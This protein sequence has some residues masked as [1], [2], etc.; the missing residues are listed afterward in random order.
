MRWPWRGRDAGKGREPEHLRTGRWGEREAERY[1]QALGFR[2]LG[3]RLRVG[4]RDE[5][6]LLARDKD[7]LVFVEVKTR[8]SE[9][10]GRPA[11]AVDRN[12]RQALSRA[13]LRYM[14]KLKRKPDFFRFDVVEVV[15]HPDE[16]KPEVTHIRSA[17]TMS[18]RYRVPW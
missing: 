2:I 17:F 12:K 3:R 18:S 6:D 5:L 14:L 8:R 9:D 4:R 15:G 10:F 7:C 16:G 13:A 11:A 1:L